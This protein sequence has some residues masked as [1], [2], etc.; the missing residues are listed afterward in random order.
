[1][2]I[3]ITFRHMEPTEALKLYIEKKLKKVKRYLK[4]PIEAHVV[5][6]KEKFMHITEVNITAGNGADIH[7]IEK[8]EDA[9]E[10]IDMVVDKLERQI[11]RQMDKA[12]HQKKRR[13]WWRKD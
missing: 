10:A 13:L 12:R 1:M 7:G 5:I 9:H 6:G 4:E 3:N 8:K 2:Q 11:K